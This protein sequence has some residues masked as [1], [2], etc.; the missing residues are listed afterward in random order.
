MP[1]RPFPRVLS[2]RIGL[3][4]NH[5]LERVSMMFELMAEQQRDREYL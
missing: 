4:R 5:Q 1:L 3:N 2:T